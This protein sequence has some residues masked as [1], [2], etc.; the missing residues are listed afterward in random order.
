M[1]TGNDDYT[2]QGKMDNPFKRRYN[3]KSIGR[4]LLALLAVLTVLSSGGCTG[5]I[6]PKAGSIAPDN[7]VLMLDTLDAAP[8]VWEAGDVKLDFSTVQAGNRFEISGDIIF[9]RR[10]KNNFS[11]PKSFSLILSFVDNQYRVIQASNIEPMIP[12]NYPVPEKVKFS[13]VLELPQGSVG[14]V[15]NYFGIF[16]GDDATMGDLDIYFSPYR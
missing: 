13:K 7:A 12:R 4:N 3:M 14:I 9:S 10:M 6:K 1:Q 16:S 2:M 11:R 15:F 8:Q 5:F